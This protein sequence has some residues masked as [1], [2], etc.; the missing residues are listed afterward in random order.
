VFEQLKFRLSYS[1]RLFFRQDDRDTS[2][3]DGSDCLVER[4]LS[5]L[6]FYGLETS[7]S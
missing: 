3:P 1:I 4:S 6:L 2:A 5:D 7:S